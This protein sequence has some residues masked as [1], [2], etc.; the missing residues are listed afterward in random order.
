MEPLTP[1]QKEPETDGATSEQP[2]LRRSLTLPWLVLYGLGV[3]IGAGIYVLLGASV[4]EAGVYAPISFIGASVVMIFSAL[5][6]AELSGRFPVSAGEAAYVR[7]GFRSDKLSLLVGFLVMTAGTVSAAAITVGSA[8]YLGAFIPISEAWL[9]VL[10]VLVL[11]GITIIGIRES[12]VFA[13]FFTLIEVGALLAIIWLGVSHKP[14][15]LLQL[16]QVVPEITDMAAWM[17]VGAAGLLAFFAFIGFE[18]IVNLAEEVQEPKKTVPWAIILTLGLGTLIY[19]MVTAVAV[20]SVPIDGLAASTTPVSYLFQQVT[21]APNTL[22]TS[23]AIIATLNGVI[24]QMIMSS[25]VLYGLGKQGNLPAFVARINARTQT[26][27]NASGLI[28]LVILV[29]SVAL[30]I[31]ELAEITSRVVLVVFTLVNLALLQIKV[32]RGA[33]PEGT[34]EVWFWVPAAGAVSCVALLATDFI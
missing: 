12:V 19:F 16:D 15:L 14:E 9:S 28:I 33:P 3:T 23:I 6:F 1:G 34:F 13:S 11:G 17:G 24:I 29:L 5:S 26:P 8:G 22:I 27:V 4:A 25:R 2:A 32:R 10:I 31:Q 21:G 18:D 30:P 20:L 7:A